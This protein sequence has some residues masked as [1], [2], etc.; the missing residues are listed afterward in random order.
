MIP[1]MFLLLA[2][3]ALSAQHRPTP[4]L[5]VVREYLNPSIDAEHHQIEEDA[6]KICFDLKCPNPYL[7]L[8]SVTGPSEVWYVN[9]FDSQAKVEE[10]RQAY[11]NNAQLAAALAANLKRKDA[12]LSAKSTESLLKFRKD[13]TRGPVWTIGQG[14]YLSVRWTKD[15]PAIEGTVFEGDDGALLIVRAAQSREQADAMAVEM[16]TGTYILSVR[17]ELGM[18]AKEWIQA[19][20]DFWKENRVAKGK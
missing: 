5:F 12:L 4:I 1:C 3:I 20:P 17:P 13:L 15:K 18:A 9:G 8:K 19:D 16:G 7:V 14:R 11:A 6:A 10:V 2:G